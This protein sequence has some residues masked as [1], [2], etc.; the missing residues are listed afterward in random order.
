MRVLRMMFGSLLV[1]TA[2]SAGAQVTGVVTESSA[3]LTFRPGADPS[4]TGIQ[5]FNGEILDQSIGSEAFGSGGTFGATSQV[6]NGVI[7]FR[8]GNGSGGSFTYLTSRTLV[9]ISFTNDGNQAVTPTLHSTITPAGLGI[10]TGPSC[11]QNLQSCGP[12]ESYPGDFR[13]FQDFFP[14]GRDP[15]SDMIAGA[16]F[17][18]R[19]AGGGTTVYELSG[20]VMLVRDELAGEN[21][22][23]GDLGAAEAALAG[24]RMISTPGSQQEFSFAWDATDLLVDFPAGT[25]LQPGE[26]ST[27]TYETVVETFSRASCFSLLT[28]ACVFA[29][30]AF[31]DP[32]GRGGGVNPSLRAAQFAALPGAHALSFDTY[33]FAAPTFRDGE[34]SF[35]LIGLAPVPEPQ[36]WAAMILGF[37]LVGGVARWRRRSLPPADARC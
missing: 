28:G 35:E 33:I 23:V 18:F 24:F 30:S 12:G 20:N 7:E 4:D 13:D 37:G 31:G 22:L 32:V 10:Y 29:Y 8:N 16:S 3:T 27:L 1:L 19:I 9:D 25:I 11:L 5:I 15:V 6:G 26:S 36:I 17:S 2:T 14:D 34:L 21:I